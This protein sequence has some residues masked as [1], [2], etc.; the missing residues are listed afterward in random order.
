M[1]TTALNSVTLGRGS[2]ARVTGRV[3]VLA[4]PLAF[5]RLL[6][7]LFR[8]FALMTAMMPHSYECG[9][10][11]IGSAG[12]SDRGSPRR[13]HGVPDYHPEQGQPV[14]APGAVIPGTRHGD[15]AEDRVEGLVPIAGE[16]GLV[17][18]PARDARPAVAPVGGQDLA[19]HGTAQPQQ[20]GPD[21]LLGGLQAGIAAAQG[22]GCLSGQPS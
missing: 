7:A 8:F 14:P 16:R 22:T 17:P 12:T 10:V 21:H 2:C 20:P 15:Q 18:V 11:F 1:T 3:R 6:A 13:L 19:Q 5:F 4:D 9:I